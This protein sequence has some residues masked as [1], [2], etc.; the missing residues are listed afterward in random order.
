MMADAKDAEALENGGSTDYELGKL[1]KTFEPI[2]VDRRLKN[3]DT[4]RLGNTELVALHH[5]GHTKGS[6]SY[7]VDVKDEKKTYR[8]LIA[9]MPSIITERKFS[10]IPSY[11]DIAKDYA[12]TLEEMKKLSFDLWLSSHAS[13]FGLHGKHKPGDPYNP[14]A[15]SDR[16]GYEQSLKDLEAQYLKKIAAE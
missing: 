8:V 3:G 10:D 7:L 12:Y 5:P 4:I 13:Q 6:C 15:F 16:K 9:N 11:P 2:H 14:E 1:G